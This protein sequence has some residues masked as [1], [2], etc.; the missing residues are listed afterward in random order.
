M[1]RHDDRDRFKTLFRLKPYFEAIPIAWNRARADGAAEDAA[2]ETL[3]Q[4]MHAHAVRPPLN[5]LV[6]FAVKVPEQG[7]LAALA[8]VFASWRWFRG[9]P[10]GIASGF[11]AGAVAGAGTDT[12]P[13][14]GRPIRREIFRLAYALARDGVD[15][16]QRTTMLRQFRTLFATSLAPS[17]DPVV[18]AEGRALLAEHLADLRRAVADAHTAGIVGKALHQLRAELAKAIANVGQ[19]RQD[20]AGRHDCDD[21]IVRLEEA[22]VLHDEA[23]TFPERVADEK[24]P[25]GLYH[26][27]R[28]RGTCQ[29]LLAQAITDPQRRLRLLDGAVADAR[30]ARNLA[31][32]NQARLIDGS[33]IVVN[34]VNAMKDRLKLRLQLGRVSKEQASRELGDIRLIARDAASDR[35]DPRGGTLLQQMESG[36]DNLDAAITGS[37]PPPSVERLTLHIEAALATMPDPEADPI[38]ASAVQAVVQELEHWPPAMQLPAHVMNGLGGFFAGLHIEV[39]GPQ[40]SVR[41]MAQESRLLH[42]ENGA[43]R[44]LHPSVSQVWDP[45]EYVEQ[46]ITGFRTRICNPTWAHAEKRVAAGWINILTSARLTWAQKGRPIDVLTDLRLA[47]LSGST[48]WRSDLAFYGT[49]P[50]T[51]GTGPL[52]TEAEFRCY[53]FRTRW[54]RDAAAEFLHH[55]ELHEMMSRATGLPIPVFPE[56]QFAQGAHIYPRGTSRDVIRAESSVPE[57]LWQETPDGIAVPNVVTEATARTASTRHLQELQEAYEKM[58][59]NGWAPREFPDL[60]EATPE[61]LREWL[62]RQND[63]AIISIGAGLTPSIVGHDGKNIWFE[64]IDQFSEAV[65]RSIL[66]YQAARDEHSFGA[67]DETV[68]VLDTTLSEAEREA[69]YRRSIAT[70]SATA[71]LDAAL[72][73]M[74]IGLGGAFG[75]SLLR[76][77]ARGVRC[78]L[79]LPREWARHVPWFAVPVGE[80]TLGDV[81]AASVVETLA[82]IPRVRARVGPSALYVGGRAGTASPLALGKA[83]LAPLSDNAAGPTDRDTFE[84]MASTARVLRVFAHGTSMLLYTE[85][86]GIE[87]DEDD[88]RPINRYSVAEARMLDLRGARRVELW[89][90]ES[91]RGDAV[92]SH[93]VHHDEPT[94]MDAAVLLAGAECVVASLW[95]QYVLSSAMIA[96]AFTLEL[97]ARPQPEAEAL[98]AAIRRYRV[99]LDEGGVFAEA[100]AASL[101]DGARPVRVETVLRAGLDR[102]RDQAWTDLLGRSPSAL[103]PEMLL[104]GQR[105]GPS[106]A[107]GPTAIGARGDLLGQLLA[108]YRS[109][110]AWAG[111]RV[112]LRSKET[113]DPTPAAEC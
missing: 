65:G 64:R 81:F 39:A 61:H 43:P 25:A 108:P 19:S 17:E 35:G 21:P 87:M 98:S 29:R 56:A 95:T 57:H 110:L 37:R 58:A 96:E 54:E 8:V 49:G 42:L 2:V 40:L 6:M 79:I 12:D 103:P 45:V 88:Q 73:R 105:L 70:P 100:A 93:L 5:E 38:E 109:P 102:W 91:G 41:A 16:P 78:V 3:L 71:K 63:V 31:R 66:E 20:F 90:C 33:L 80:R 1:S 75:P 94:G 27:L 24:D 32:S 77:E 112:T 11:F 69:R 113:L 99:G 18:A 34:L 26:S 62:A 76:A 59:R 74:L 53:L 7:L 47:D 89:A 86:A 50:W 36:L 48:A 44:R 82:P 106:V 46:G 104:G 4:A 92:Y 22:L 52:A 85:G 60:P 30:S 107:H 13:R 15:T 97:G 67:V 28:M 72:T 101:R 84:A 55:I 83:V 9:T 23:L 14:S 10:E 51:Q 111:W 68:D